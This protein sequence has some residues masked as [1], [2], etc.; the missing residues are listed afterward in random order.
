MKQKQLQWWDVVILSLILFGGAI[1]SSTTT[2]FTVSPEILAQGTEFTSADNYSAMFST[3]IELLFAYIYLR[4][5]QFD[6]SQW[7]YHI[8]WKDT[9]Y[10]LGIFLLLSLSMDVVSILSLG[11]SEATA[12]VGELGILSALAEVDFSLVAFSL[13][14]G[15]YEEIFFL[16]ICT[17][18]PKQQQKGVLLYSFVIRFSF[19]TY[20]GLAS[21]LG[22][23]LLV[24]GIYYWLYQKKSQNLYPYMLSHS[25]ADI[26]GLGI[27]PL[28]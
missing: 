28:L 1:W 25:L 13:L 2:F 11:W 9:F 22:I 18:V 16:G 7:K 6:F 23:G 26:I 21:A 15:F 17:H 27:L 19:H 10:A 24:G 20:Q 3:V 4:W 12:Y 14:N 8:T 5:R